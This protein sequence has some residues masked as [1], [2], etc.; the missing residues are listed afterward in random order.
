MHP[1][2]S[3]GKVAREHPGLDCMNRSVKTELP[4]DSSPVLAEVVRGGMVES[5]HHASVAVVDAH[6]GIVHAWGDIDLPIYG[7]SAIK[8]LLAIPLVESGAADRFKLSVAEIALATASHNSEPRHVETVTAWLERIGL[9]IEDLECG[10][11]YPAHEPTM[12]AML[13]AQQ[14]PN[15]A[16]NNCSGKHAGFLATA[17]HLGEPTKGYIQYEHPVQRRLLGLLEQ[18]SALELGEAPRG[19]D[20]CGIPVI[21]IPIANTAL[22]MARMADPHHLPDERAAA[23]RRILAAMMAD[24][25]MVAGTDRFCTKLMS[26]VPGKAAIKVGAEGVYCGALPE[27]GLGIC[28][29]VTDGAS[30]ACEVVMG[31]VLRHLGVIDEAMAEELGKTLTPEIKNWAGTPTGLVRPAF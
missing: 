5:R 15:R 26:A 25:F 16:H 31:Q 22:A 20:G 13:R 12:Q 2:A 11:H 29:K 1:A 18:M 10:A 8:P 21:A 27:L 3:G 28:L 6:G 17:I 9:G 19:I 24:P 23:C 7:R 14:E 4:Q 30:R